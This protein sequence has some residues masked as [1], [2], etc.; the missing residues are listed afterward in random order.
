MLAVHY[1]FEIFILFIF[2]PSSIVRWRF[3]LTD[4]VEHDDD[5]AAADFHG[6]NRIQRS[7]R[8]EDDIRR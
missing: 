2:F 1:T 5:V 3:R 6:C 8:N 7:G 4:M